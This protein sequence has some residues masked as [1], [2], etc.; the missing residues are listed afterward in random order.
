MY[1]APGTIYEDLQAWKK[2]Q[3]KAITHKNFRNAVCKVWDL[4]ETYY[5]D[6]FGFSLRWETLWQV[7]LLQ[8]MMHA[9]KERA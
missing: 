7:Y 8:E 9:Q 2:K 1:F 4:P 3:K 6:G 5:D